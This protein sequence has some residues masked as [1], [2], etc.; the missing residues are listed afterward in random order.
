MRLLFLS[1]G[2]L[3]CSRTGGTQEGPATRTSTILVMPAAPEAEAPPSPFAVAPSAS[4]PARAPAEP[5]T[6]VGGRFRVTP[7]GGLSDH[8]AVGGI[9][10]DGRGAAYSVLFYDGKPHG[11]DRSPLYSAAR[12]HLGDSAIDKETDTAFD[13]HK[14]RE[15]TLHVTSSKGAVVYSRDVMVISGDRTYDVSVTSPER[16]R[17]EDA[18]ANAFF[19]SFHVIDD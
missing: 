4:G 5:F 15:K 8:L 11:V 13:G 9:L 3:G 16:A 14:A 19:S 10:W 12:D 6:S 1:L 2:L 18:E 17:V 7:P